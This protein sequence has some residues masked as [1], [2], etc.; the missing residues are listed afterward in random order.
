M[1][2]AHKEQMDVIV[3]ILGGKHYFMSKLIFPVKISKIKN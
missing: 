1:K 3:Y 2:K